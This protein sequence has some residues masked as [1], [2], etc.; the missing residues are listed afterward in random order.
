MTEDAKKLVQRWFEEVWN[1][2]R[3]EAITEMFA[4]GKEAHGLPEQDSVIR[5]P[6]EFKT[7]YRAMVATFPDIHVH[8]DDLIG[9]GDRVAVRWTAT[10][11]HL[12]DG[13]G[14]APTGK[15]LSLSGSSFLICQ[16]GNDRHGVEPYGLYPAARSVALMLRS[17]RSALWN[18]LRLRVVLSHSLLRKRWGTPFS[19]L[20]M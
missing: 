13:L 17:V 6:E 11:T 15:K 7:F 8:L 12:G 19:W 16:R 2:K 4:E 9:E 18:V 3:E 5:G 14:Y 10:M 1:K 20:P